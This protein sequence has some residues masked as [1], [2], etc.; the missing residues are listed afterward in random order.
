VIARKRLLPGFLQGVRAIQTALLAMLIVLVPAAPRAVGASDSPG[1]T[2]GAASCRSPRIAT[3]DGCVSAAQASR[4]VL[5]LAQTLRA[6]HD[7][8]AV[9][10]RIDVGRRRL[11]RTGLGNSMDGVPAT[12]RMHW[13][14]GSIALQLQ[15]EGKLSLG[16]RLSTWFPEL[17]NADR[18]TLRMLASSTSG[19]RDYVQN[20]P[21]FLDLLLSNPFRQW[22]EEELVG[23]ALARPVACEPG[24]CFVYSH[25]NFIILGQVLERVTGRTVATLMRRRILRPLGLRNTRISELPAIPE[26][27]LHAYSSD[28]TVYEDST[29]WS[30]SWTI[31]RGVIQ[32]STVDDVIK[33]ARAIGS[34]RLLSRRAAAEQVAP[35][36]AGLPPLS[37]AFYYGLG[38]NVAPPW[39]FQ[40]PQLNG[41]SGIMAYLPDKRLSIAIVSTV[42]P[43]SPED[44]Q[45]VVLFRRIAAYLAPEHPL[46]P[47]P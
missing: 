5:A 24:T 19:Y 16:D 46:P 7:L 39:R 38:V 41:Y 12:P 14:I 9:I 43:R 20:N 10:L 47:G 2:G 34:G 28:R 42:G 30:P 44:S 45:S 1:Q 4:R 15:D 8:A 29:F 17:P 21:P 25:A 18:I 37:P 35:N 36:T 31:G 32:T 40:N 23:V 11:L 33:S 6:E 22:T 3:A 13:R 27:A 26:P